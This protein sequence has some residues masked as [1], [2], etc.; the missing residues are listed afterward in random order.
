MYLSLPAGSNGGLADEMPELKARARRTAKV[1]ALAEIDDFPT[2]EDPSAPGRELWHV[3][4]IG[5]DAL[6]RSYHLRMNPSKPPHSETTLSSK[7]GSMFPL[8]PPPPNVQHTHCDAKQYSI[9]STHPFRTD[10]GTTKSFTG[11]CN[12]CPM[13]GR[14]HTTLP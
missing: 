8:P 2:Q 14:I 11:F 1:R 9:N 5:H 10:P 6:C 7:G 3:F 4:P 12:T 13:R